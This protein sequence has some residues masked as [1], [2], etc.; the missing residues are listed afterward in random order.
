MAQG[1]KSAKC[2]EQWEGANGVIK[3]MDFHLH[4]PLETERLVLRHFSRRDADAMFAYRGREDVA[5]Y[6]MDEALTREECALAIQQRIN[7]VH[8]DKVDSRLTLAVETRDGTLVGEVCLILRNVEARQ[9]EIG[10]IF[11]PD[12]Q[13]K[14]YASEA[15]RVLLALAFQSAELHRVFARCDAANTPSWRLMERLGMRKEAHFIEHGL[16]KGRWDEELYYA[17]LSRE[18]VAQNQGS[19]TLL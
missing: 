14:G 13:G 9:G 19:K 7:H 3:L 5:Q 6:L 10:W 1:A 15:C 4:S 11:H 16:F 2:F 8:L 12:H 18:W 17:M